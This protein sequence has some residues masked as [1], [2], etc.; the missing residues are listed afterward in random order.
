MP[1]RSRFRPALSFLLQLSVSGALIWILLQ[2]TD[3]TDVGSKLMKFSLWSVVVAVL[4]IILLTVL[5][6]LRWKFIVSASRGK[7]SAIDAVKIVFLGNFWNQVLPSSVGGDV[8]RAWAAKRA[9]LD[10]G[11]AITTVLLDRL[12]AVASL[13]IGIALG[14]PWLA[15]MIQGATARGSI[16]LFVGL[17]VGCLFFLYFLQCI[18]RSL[19]RWKAMRFVQRIV[20]STQRVIRHRQGNLAFALSLAIHGGTA[21]AVFILAM[22]LNIRVGLLDCLLLMPPVMLISMLPISIAGWGLRESAMVIALA[23]VGVPASDALAISIVFGAVGMLASFPGAVVWLHAKK[24]TVPEHAP[25]FQDKILP[26]QRR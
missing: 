7:L 2:T 13:I 4:L 15:G 8:V 24:L 1:H 18:P 21:L 14:L 10:M 23:I 9:G 5:H 17:S 3:M 20:D 12:I 16:V 26:T 22:G 25:F 6:G 19:L 11:L